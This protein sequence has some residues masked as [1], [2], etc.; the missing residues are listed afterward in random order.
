VPRQ[1]AIAAALE[2][3]GE[4]KV[5][6]ARA[7]VWDRPRWAVTIDQGKG[8]STPRLVEVVVDGVTG[9]VLSTSRT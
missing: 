9:K 2:E 3:A 4:G 5:K 7:D 6:E 1:K 8:E